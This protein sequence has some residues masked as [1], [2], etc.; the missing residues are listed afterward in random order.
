MYP[1]SLCQEAVSTESLEVFKQV[2]NSGW[3]QNAPHLGQKTC[4][5]VRWSPYL[6]QRQDVRSLWISTWGHEQHSSQSWNHSS[7]WKQ[8]HPEAEKDRAS[9]GGQVGLTHASLCSTSTC[10]SWRSCTLWAIA[11]PWWCSWLLSAS[12]VVSG[13][14]TLQ[15]AISP[16]FPR[17]GLWVS[18]NSSGQ[19]AGHFVTSG[20]KAY[21]WQNS[22]VLV[23]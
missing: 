5:V 10:W 2:L 8:V 3:W 13:E 22:E 4:I 18:F 6:F 1:E 23:T 9:Q 14:N 20:S 16:A 17:R 12:S 7:I 21:L 11:P 19:R 15:L